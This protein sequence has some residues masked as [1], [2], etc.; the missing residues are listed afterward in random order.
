MFEHIE[1]YYGWLHL[2]SHEM[3]EMSPFHE[4]EHN[5]FYFDRHVYTFNAHP[6]W[7]SIESESLLMKILFVD[8]DSGYTIIELFG[9]WN[10]LFENDFKL[11]CENC[12]DI[13]LYYGVEKYIFICENVF[14]IYFE[15][16]DYY[17]HFMEQLEEGWMCVLKARSNVLE[18]FVKYD[19]QQYF[20]WNHELDK[21]N[22]RKLKPW[23]IKDKIDA[24]I[25]KLLV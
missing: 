24:S 11:M 12:L 6:L 17:S 22:W 14:N 8:Y 15:H 2:Y 16:D 21:L 18:E 13:M 19:I 10:D 25:S 4:V 7:D 1:P 20:Y 23:E 9:E 3:D 5:L